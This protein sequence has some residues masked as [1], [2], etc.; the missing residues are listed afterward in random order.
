MKVDFSV[1][2]KD[3]EHLGLTDEQLQ[4]EYVTK[5]YNYNN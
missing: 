1:F 3:N 2:C 4:K 5:M